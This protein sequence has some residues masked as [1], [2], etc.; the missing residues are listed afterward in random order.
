[1]KNI[2]CPGGKIKIQ[3]AIFGRTEEKQCP[4]GSNFYCI[5]D[6]IDK[7]KKS[8][9]GKESCVVVAS[10]GYLKIR[11]HPCLK[12]SKYLQINKTCESDGKIH[13][14]IFCEA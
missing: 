7:I 4:R 14:N 3:E 6:V 8:C 5:I 10:K 11:Y 12:Y 2:S 1:M 9:E 13:I